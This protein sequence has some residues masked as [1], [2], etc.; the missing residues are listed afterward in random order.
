MDI[1]HPLFQYA[2]EHSAP[3]PELLKALRRETYQ[4]VLNPRMLS[5]HF[6]GRLLA[7]IATLKQPKN[8]LEIG[9]YTGYS[10]LCLAEG[11]PSDGSIVT[12]EKN[13]ELLILQEK[14]FNQS[15]LRKKIKNM[16]GDAISVIPE[17]DLTFDLVFIDG[18]KTEYKTYFDLIFPKLNKGGIIL[19]DNVLWHGKVTN[20]T[21]YTDRETQHIIAYNAFLKDFEEVEQLVLPLRDGL[22]IGVK[23]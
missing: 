12:I 14:Y 9:T 1:N 21:L 18:Q 22:S 19:S 3:E 15:P 5:G 7:L 23:K 10:T 8:I 17:L 6:Q 16:I 13:E 20:P 4:K 11:L 2:I